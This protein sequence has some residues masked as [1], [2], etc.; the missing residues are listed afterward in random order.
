MTLKPASLKTPPG[1]WTGKSRGAIP[2]CRPGIQCRPIYTQTFTF[3]I[4]HIMAHAQPDPNIPKFSQNDLARLYHRHFG[5]DA[6]G[7]ERALMA[8]MGNPFGYL[9][10][11]EVSYLNSVLVLM[12]ELFDPIIQR[13]VLEPTDN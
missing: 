3:K 2:F 13:R 12:H 11:D 7:P 6:T 10:Q 9:S 5:E 4:F 1:I 8:A